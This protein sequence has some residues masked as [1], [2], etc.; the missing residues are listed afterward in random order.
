MLAAQ[1]IIKGR[2]R[3][4]QQL[5]K[6]PARQTWLAIDLEKNSTVVIKLLSFGGQIQWNDLKLF[7]REGQILRELNHPFIPKYHDYFSIDERIL[8]FALV[9]QYIPGLSLQNSLNRGTRLSE[10]EVKDIALK[11]LEILSY[12][13]HLNPQVL[14]RDIKPSNIILGEDKQIYLIDFGAVQDKAA[15]EGASFTV[16]G[17]YGYTP[18]EQFGGRAVASSDL[19]A[20]GATLIHLLTGIPP[21]DL[22]QKDLRIQ[23]QDKVE[24]S[25]HLVNVL[26]KMTQP[27]LE[28]RFNNASEVIE[29]FKSPSTL[30]IDKFSSSLIRER[31]KLVKNHNELKL[32]IPHRYLF[33]YLQTQIITLMLPIFF[34]PITT[35]FS[36]SYDL[37]LT[38]FDLWILSTLLFVL[39]IILIILF[40][41]YILTTIIKGLK[42]DI[43]FRKEQFIVNF[44]WN[45]IKIITKKYQI[46]SIK[47]I[48]SIYNEVIKIRLNNQE[49]IT[50]V[51]NLNKKES[52]CLIKEIKDWLKIK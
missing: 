11:I 46:S 26:E 21:A 29:A 6:N 4:Q 9:Q 35:H 51:Q 24:I 40:Y 23:F 37:F 19:Y 15:K 49:E 1:E 43:Y 22:P 48:N 41:T 44:R 7:E 14:H 52:D 50:L 2:Y 42:R 36:P 38:R 34:L 32:T 20:L 12:L 28:N 25:Q 10:S 16:V 27:A 18:I 33:S 17:T 39:L 8:G 30:T 31:F 45:N 3:L 47:N 13:H 5:G